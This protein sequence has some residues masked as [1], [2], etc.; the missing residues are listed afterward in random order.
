MINAVYPVLLRKKQQ[1]SVT[2]RFIQ[3]I[4]AAI[5][6]GYSFPTNLDTDPPKDGYA[7]QPEA[8]LVLQALTEAW[9]PEQVHTALEAYASPR[10]A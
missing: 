3:D 1:K 4:L 10:K 9:P 2:D 7:P 8:K 6:D 5:A